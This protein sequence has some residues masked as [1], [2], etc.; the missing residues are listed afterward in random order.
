A[1]SS[2]QAAEQ[3]GKITIPFGGDRPSALAKMAPQKALSPFAS[4][5]GAVY[6]HWQSFP[7]HIPAREAKCLVAGNCSMRNPLSE[8]GTTARI[9]NFD[10]VA[11]FRRAAQD[12]PRPNILL[13]VPS[14]LRRQPFVVALQRPNK[15]VRGLKTRQKLGA[16]LTA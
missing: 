5:R 14:K 15:R 10:R 3:S 1:A 16:S 4:C 7:G 13:R 9:Q 11:P 8:S 6:P 12:A 2:C